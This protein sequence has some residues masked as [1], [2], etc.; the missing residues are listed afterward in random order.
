MGYFGSP[1][2]SGGESHN[3]ANKAVLDQL[4]DPGS[5]QVITDAERQTITA[6]AAGGSG[7]ENDWAGS[8]P[9]TKDE[10]IARLARV[11]KQHL[12]TPIPEL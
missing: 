11:L 1:G 5:G 8:V 12:G 7:G 10:A 3:H 4:A 9:A 6:F 2:T